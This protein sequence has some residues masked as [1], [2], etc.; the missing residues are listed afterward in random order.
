MTSIPSFT[1]VL[2]P[3]GPLGN[4]FFSLEQALEAAREMEAAGHYIKAITRGAVTILEGDALREALGP[5]PESTF[6]GFVV[7]TNDDG[8]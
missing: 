1:I 5:R 7:S 3:S 4:V 8:R 6:Q 2:D